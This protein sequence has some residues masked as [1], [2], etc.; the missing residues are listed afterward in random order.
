MHT[1]T[2]ALYKFIF[3]SI[4]FF[5]QSHGYTFYSS[6]FVYEKTEAWEDYAIGLRSVYVLSII[7]YK[8]N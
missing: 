2:D 4:E 7:V 5:Q 3:K 8:S 6:Y 1:Y